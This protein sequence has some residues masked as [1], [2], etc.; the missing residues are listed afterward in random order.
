[1]IIETILAKR[2]TGYSKT[3]AGFVNSSYVDMSVPYAAGSL[4]ST[5]RDLYK[6]DRSLYTDKGALS[7]EPG[8]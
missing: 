6:W 7:S 3:P 2:A 5:A 1:M 8:S 4:Y